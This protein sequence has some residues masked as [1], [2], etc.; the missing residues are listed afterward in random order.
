MVALFY[1]FIL[2]VSF[3]PLYWKCDEMHSNPVFAHIFLIMF[4][5]LAGLILFNSHTIPFLKESG[6][7][8]FGTFDRLYI[9]NHIKSHSYSLTAFLFFFGEVGSLSFDNN[10][11][12]VTY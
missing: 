3:L 8:I 7:L 9:R 6:K 5:F 2:V 1:V 4:S 12:T 11:N 10:T